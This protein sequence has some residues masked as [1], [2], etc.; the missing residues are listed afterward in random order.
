MIIVSTLSLIGPKLIL[1][2][3]YCVVTQYVTVPF[4]LTREPEI[5]RGFTD[6][7]CCSPNWPAYWLGHRGNSSYVVTLR[8]VQFSRN[9]SDASQRCCKSGRLQGFSPQA[10][11]IHATDSFKVQ[12]SGKPA[13]QQ[14]RQQFYLT[15]KLWAVKQ[16]NQK[17]ALE[18]VGQRDCMDLCQWIP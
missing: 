8:V 3:P 9:S 2:T 16:A 13:V 15:T 10:A 1:C 11:G 7:R 18:W 14:K 12:S 4:S 5:R 17:D 6:L